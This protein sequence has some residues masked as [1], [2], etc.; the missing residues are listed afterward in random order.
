M[1]TLTQTQPPLTTTWRQKLVEGLRWATVAG[2]FMASA[3]AAIIGPSG[4]EVLMRC[5]LTA[6]LAA[7]AAF[8]VH[9]RRVPNAVTLALVGL[10]S[11]FVP[12]RW[13]DHSLGSQAVF[14]VV[15]TWLVCLALWWLRVVGGGDA[16]LLIGLLT[17]LPS[18]ELVQA[19]LG[20]TLIGSLVTLALEDGGAGL[21]RLARLVTGRVPLDR[22]A[23]RAAYGQHGS[24]TVVWLA[25][26]TAV[27][28]LTPVFI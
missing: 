8:D 7:L 10:A 16:K 22:G 6:L 4:R 2:I 15:T 17:L 26:G 18:V 3:S 5:T 13:W 28:L 1:T 11:L 19:L 12:L 24:P 27:H 9:N 20:A 21:W 14:I 25:A 23:I